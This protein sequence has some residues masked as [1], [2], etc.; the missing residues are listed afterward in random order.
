MGPSGK[1]SKYTFRLNK[2]MYDAVHHYNIGKCT[3]RNA[4]SGSPYRKRRQADLDAE[5][6]AIQ[7]EMDDEFEGKATYGG[8][9]PKPS[10]VNKLDN[11]CRKFMATVWND[12]TLQDCPKLGAW[13]NR[14]KA[15]LDDLTAMKNVCMNGKGSDQ[16][17]DGPYGG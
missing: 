13:E 17:G 8:S 7:A 10:Q 1:I 9:T 4:D 3:P 5:F 12:P 16:Q 6:D 2:V 14:S 11:L 15:L